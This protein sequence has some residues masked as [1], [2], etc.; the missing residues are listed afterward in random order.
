LRLFGPQEVFIGIDQQFDLLGVLS[1]RHWSLVVE[2]FSLLHTANSWEL[3][4]WGWNAHY[5]FTL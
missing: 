2:L 3:W 4:W 1:S 5:I